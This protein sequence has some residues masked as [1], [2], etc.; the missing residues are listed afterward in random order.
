MGKNTI[1]DTKAKIRE[2]IKNEI[3][4]GSNQCYHR[5]V[6]ILASNS[7]V[8]P[9]GAKV[10]VKMGSVSD[11]T[12]QH[13][14]TLEILG[15]CECDDSENTSPDFSYKESALSIHYVTKAN[16]TDGYVI[17]NESSASSMLRL[18][19]AM[20]KIFPWLNFIRNL[21]KLIAHKLVGHNIISFCCCHNPNIANFLLGSCPD[22]I[23]KR[24]GEARTIQDLHLGKAESRKSIP[25]NQHRKRRPKN[26]TLPLNYM[27]RHS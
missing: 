22:L 13:T 2:I 12:T 6:I 20:K 9:S 23:A 24:S 27:C 4:P 10:N 8:C 5:M 3:L 17:S 1:L 18:S 15:I 11:R 14:S 26:S 19:P 16:Q 25:G 21:K 7:T